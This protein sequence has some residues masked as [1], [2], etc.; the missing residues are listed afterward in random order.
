MTESKERLA[1]QKIREELARVP[2]YDPA[3]PGH[4]WLLVPPEMDAL[5]AHALQYLCQFLKVDRG[6]VFLLDDKKQFLLARQLFNQGEVLPGE[7]EIAVLPGSALSELISGKQEWLVLGNPTPTAYVPLRALGETL[8]VVRVDCVFHKRPFKKSDLPVLQDFAHELAT[9]I[10]GLEMAAAERHQVHEM[11]AMHEISNAIFRSLRLDEMLDSVGQTLIRQLGFDRCKIFLI[12]KEGDMLER[13]FSL[14]QRR[15]RDPEK[16]EYPLKRDVHP[17]VDLILGKAN[18]ARIQKY[19]RTVVY[20]PLRTR[21]EN[22]GILMVDNL[23]SQQEIPQEQRPVLSAIAGQ[24]A[25]GIKNARLFQGVE[26]LSI[27][28]GLTGLYLLRYFKQRLKEEFFR[29]QRNK[30]NLSLMI[31]DV[32]HFKRSN[33]TYGHPAGD[34]ILSAVA[35]RILTN[36]RKIDITARYGGDEFIIL[37]PDTSADEARLLADRL[38]HAISNYPVTLPD[39]TSVQVTVSIGIATYPLHADNIDLLVKRSDE[40]LYWI[41]SHGRNRIHLYQHPST[42]EDGTTV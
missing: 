41:K 1:L 7:E 28:D 25:M 35:E 12:N 34:L 40:A 4:R 39:K 22:L 33:D 8:G 20:L 15:R 19:E 30:G 13:V 3:Q 10:R 38:H 26:E 21:D 16:E 27:T 23:L 37:L 2:R 31:M 18:D 29:E 14:D 24:L 6:A 5:L 17:M 36:A 9:S 11:Q 32:D 42:P